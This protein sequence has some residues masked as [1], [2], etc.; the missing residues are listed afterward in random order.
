MDRLASLEEQLDKS[1]KEKVGQG[2]GGAQGVS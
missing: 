1:M 2:G